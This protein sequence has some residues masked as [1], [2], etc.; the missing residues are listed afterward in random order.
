[1]LTSTVED[2]PD[3]V[4][5]VSAWLHERG[6]TDG[7]PVVPPTRER[8]L[9]M[10]DG[11]TRDPAATLGDVPPVNGAATVEKLAVNAV[12][13]GCRPEYL[14]V[15]LTAFDLMLR[16]GFQLA[17]MQPTTN[18]LTPMLIVNGPI[19][20]RIGLNSSTGVMGPG[21]QANATIGRAVRL[22]LINL[23]GARPG[24]VDKCTQGFVG[25]YTLCA[26]ENE[27]DSPWAPLSTGRGFD[28]GQDVLTVVGV[29]AAINIHDSSGDWRDVVKTLCGSLPSLGTPN[30]VDPH[31]TP[32]LALNPLHAQILD[33]GGY[34]K[35]GLRKHLVENTTLPPDALSARREH[36]RRSEGEDDF[37]VDGRI[38]IVN[39]P[40]SLLVLVTGGMGGGH[41]CFLPAGHY[42]QAASATIDI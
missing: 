20:H 9:R 14:P 15:V 33:G 31:A 13:A 35:D 24:E 6:H 11:T 3:D 19:R 10:L 7:L 22:A 16:P 34:D 21:W 4:E 37:L 8:V 12:L 2:L 40:E 41:S 25:K 38:P 32:V 39:D 42:G 17:G 30:V 1:M 36:L 18:P 27:E 29:N 28:A 23:G 26:G 5:V